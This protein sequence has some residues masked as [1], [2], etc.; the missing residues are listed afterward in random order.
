MSE[1][2]TIYYTTNGAIPTTS[3]KQY[4]GP[5]VITS[6]TNLKFIAVNSALITHPQSTQRHI[7]SIKFHLK[8]FLQ[9]Q[10]I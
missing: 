3:S 2:G 8:Y 1:N 6:T 5:I 9:A 7:Q 10:K 4:T